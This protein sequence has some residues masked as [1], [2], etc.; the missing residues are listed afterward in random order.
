[1]PST[2]LFDKPAFREKKGEL[3]DPNYMPSLGIRVAFTF[4]LDSLG[5]ANSLPLNFC[6][7]LRTVGIAFPKGHSNQAPTAVQ[8]STRGQGSAGLNVRRSDPNSD[9][10]RRKRVCPTLEISPGSSLPDEAPFAL[11]T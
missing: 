1:M 2:S 4:K 6:A 8:I 9:L 7:L 5:T 10:H 11:A 3:N